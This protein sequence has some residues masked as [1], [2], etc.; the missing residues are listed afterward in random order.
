MSGLRHSS[1]CLGVVVQIFEGLLKLDTQE[2][3]MLTLLPCAGCAWMSTRRRKPSMHHPHRKTEIPLAAPP[4]ASASVEPLPGA[5]RLAW[6]LSREPTGLDAQ[7]QQVITRV[8][9]DAEVARVHDVATEFVGMVRGKNSAE[10]GTWLAE[11][12]A[13]RVRALRM[14]A[15][16]IEWDCK[17]VRAA[18]VTPWS[19]AQCEGQITRLKLLKRQMYGRAKFDLLR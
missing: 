19:P 16:G 10:F 15:Q 6:L 1:W 11:C 13:S 4:V 12:R 5:K 3:V 2:P 17:A 8:R 18:L 7:V 14:F 9:Q